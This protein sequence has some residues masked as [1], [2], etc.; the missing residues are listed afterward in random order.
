MANKYMKRCLTWLDFREMQSKT[1]IGHTYYF[2]RNERAVEGLELSFSAGVTAEWCITRDRV[3]QFLNNLNTF[4]G[5]KHLALGI[6][7]RE[8]RT[9][10]CAKISTQM[11]LAVLVTIAANW[12]TT[13]TT[14]TQMSIS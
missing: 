12:K 5:L 6:H 10:V 14:K 4:T 8:M 1:T 7:C 2:E 13:T 11:F 9:H 3:G